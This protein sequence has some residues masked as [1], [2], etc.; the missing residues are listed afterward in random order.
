M[1]EKFMQA[2]AADI[3]RRGTKGSLKRAAKRAG[4]S[5]AE[6]A[7]ENEHSPGLLGK[8]ARLAEVFMHANHNR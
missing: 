5:T 2:A 7:K 4:K 8:R 1:A 3:K 6:F